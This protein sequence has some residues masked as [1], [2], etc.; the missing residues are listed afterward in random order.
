MHVKEFRAISSAV[1]LARTNKKAG[2]LIR[3]FRHILQ[4]EQIFF[5]SPAKDHRQHVSSILETSFP[6]SH[7]YWLHGIGREKFAICAS[8]QFIEPSRVICGSRIGKLE[9]PDRDLRGHAN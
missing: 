3:L 1:S 5:S 7:Q 9:Q 6:A 2:F 4:R 8:S